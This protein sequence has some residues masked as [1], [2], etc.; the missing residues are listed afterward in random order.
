M[1]VRHSAVG[2][3]VLNAGRG[4]NAGRP[5]SGIVHAITMPMTTLLLFAAAFIGGAL[6]A[7]AGGGMLVT[8]PALLLIGI[9]YF[10]GGIGFLMPAAFDTALAHFADLGAKIIAII[11]HALR[12]LGPQATAQQV[13]D[14]IV[15]L[16]DFSS[17]DGVY[18]FEKVPQR[19]LD[20]S[21]AVMTVWTRKPRPR[22][23]SVRPAAHRSNLV[24]DRSRAS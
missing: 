13:H 24:Q 17:I 12:T 19:G 20:L 3:A 15:H 2:E 11:V 18:D 14:F 4:S 7:L 10:G 6:N 5:A 16:K 1:L 21:N 23:L 9:S 22:R 8:F